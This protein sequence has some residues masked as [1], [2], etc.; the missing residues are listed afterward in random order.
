QVKRQQRIPAELRSWANA[1][2]NWMVARSEGTRV[3]LSE[4]DPVRQELSRAMGLFAPL[5]ADR[6]RHAEELEKTIEQERTQARQSAQLLDRS[7]ALLKRTAGERDVALSERDR[8]LGLY[9]EA[10]EGASAIRSR[11][12]QL[13]T[14]L[15]R[16]RSEL[17]G[18]DRERQ[19]LEEGL[20]TLQARSEQAQADLVRQRD[21][22]HNL[23]KE[24][25]ESLRYT[26]ESYQRQEAENKVLQESL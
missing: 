9:R 20:A 24:S 22:A 10:D 7:E 17:T 18:R 11:L 3:E 15:E 2:W 5:I 4:L 8:A 6:N 1:V 14:E 23:Y 25:Q 26:Q 12:A 13:E 19:Q 21:Q 16:A